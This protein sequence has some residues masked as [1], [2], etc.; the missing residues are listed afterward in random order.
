MNQE[1]PSAIETEVI[2]EVKFEDIEK[3]LQELTESL[4]MAHRRTTLLGKRIRSEVEEED[5]KAALR[6]IEALE[7]SYLAVAQPQGQCWFEY[8]TL[9]AQQSEV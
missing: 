5:M 3:I 6:Q 4:S 1:K 7:K 8:V 9:Q 2:E